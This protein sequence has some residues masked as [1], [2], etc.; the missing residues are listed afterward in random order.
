MKHIDPVC[1]MVVKDET[2]NAT[3]DFN[4]KTYYFCSIECKEEFRKDPEKYLNEKEPKSMPH[5]G[6][7]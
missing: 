5:K 1:G 7:C 6:S 3:Y 4:G 2:A